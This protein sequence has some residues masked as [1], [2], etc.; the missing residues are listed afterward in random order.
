[1]LK[2]KE[3]AAVRRRGVTGS[4]SKTP[5]KCMQNTHFDPCGHVDSTYGVHRGCARSSG[6]SEFELCGSALDVG[7]YSFLFAIIWPSSSNHPSRQR[8]YYTSAHSPGPP[9]LFRTISR[10]RS[11]GSPYKLPF[12]LGAV[13]DS[14]IFSWLLVGT[15]LLPSCTLRP[16]FWPWAPSHL[17]GLSYGFIHLYGS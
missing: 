10:R 13:S 17:C 8:R 1:M 5:S 11:F 4:T 7:C 12:V 9:G 6:R 2:L 16:S 14:H 3:C 15:L